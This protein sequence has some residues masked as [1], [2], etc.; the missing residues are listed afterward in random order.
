MH[1]GLAIFPLSITLIS[2]LIWGIWGAGWD[3]AAA[4]WFVIYIEEKDNIEKF[5]QTYLSYMLRVPPFSLKPSCILEGLKI[6]KS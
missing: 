3:I 1:L 5:G 6:W 4:F 2:G